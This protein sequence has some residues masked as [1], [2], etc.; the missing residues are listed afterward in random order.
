V[1]S[2]VARINLRDLVPPLWA[3]VH[4]LRRRLDALETATDP[5]AANRAKDPFA[6]RSTSTGG[7]ALH[8]VAVT[9]DHVATLL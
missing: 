7:K 2:S 3:H 5:A 4:R 6:P 9:E 1:V 8:A